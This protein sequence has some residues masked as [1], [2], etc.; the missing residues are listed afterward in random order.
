MLASCTD[1]CSGWSS[2]VVATVGASVGR[3]VDVIL[4]LKLL[5]AELAVAE[6]GSVWC[7]ESAFCSVVIVW[8]E[9]ACE[10]EAWVELDGDAS[11]ASAEEGDCAAV[12]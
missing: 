12:G 8:S 1:L 9:V 4:A 5:I 3:S 2:S 11:E 6:A 10:V 7:G